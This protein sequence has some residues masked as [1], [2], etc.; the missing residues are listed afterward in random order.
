[1]KVLL[2]NGVYTSAGVNEKLGLSTEPRGLR[3][4]VYAG[5]GTVQVTQMIYGCISLRE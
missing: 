4:Y 5:Q 3:G 2:Q 1:M